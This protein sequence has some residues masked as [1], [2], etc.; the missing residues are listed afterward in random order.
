MQDFADYG[1]WGEAA[2]FAADAGDDA[3]G[4]AEVAAV[5]D[6]EDGAGVVEFAALDGG[7]EKF[8][9]GEDV[10]AQDLCVAR[11]RIEGA[12]KKKQVPRFARNDSLFS[13][14]KNSVGWSN[15]S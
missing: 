3:V 6:F 9:V 11:V 7:G 8:G 13:I 2:A 4:A 15:L 14:W 10:A 5:L 1:V 12:R